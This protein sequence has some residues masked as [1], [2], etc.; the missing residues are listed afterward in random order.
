MA[1]DAR[2]HPADAVLGDQP[3]ARKRCGEDGVVGGKPQVAIQRVDEA[4][5]GG[6]A[7]QHADHRLWDRR[8]IG[9]TRLPVRPAGY[10]ESPGVLAP[11]DLPWVEWPESPPF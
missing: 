10:V 8:I 6:G 11:P 1:D 3:A 5:A 7:V 4:D 9:I 2:Q